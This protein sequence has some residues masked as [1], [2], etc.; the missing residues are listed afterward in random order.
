MAESAIHRELDLV[1][2]AAFTDPEDSSAWL[3]HTWLA[4][5]GRLPLSLVF[6][7][8]QGD[9]VTLATSRQVEA[10]QIVTWLGGELRQVVWEGGRLA[11]GE[12]QGGQR[13]SSLWK[14]EVPL[15]SQLEVGLEGLDGLEG[16]V[17]GERLRL[18]TTLQRTVTS[19]SW[20][21]EAA[22]SQATRYS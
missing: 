14:A 1:Q 17:E 18:D 12:W 3:Y 15:G 20:K 4:G 2:S 22:P 10:G 19:G 21:F 8:C 6:L 13:F 5:A 16:E 9:R 7:A 11:G